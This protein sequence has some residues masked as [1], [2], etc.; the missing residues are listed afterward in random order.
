MPNNFYYSESEESLIVV[1]SDTAWQKRYFGS[2]KDYPKWVSYGIDD[3]VF[4]IT[5]QQL[6][7]QSVVVV[8]DVI[9]ATKVGHILPTLTL[10]GSKITANRIT[11]LLLLGY[12]NIILWLDPDKH[13]YMV[14]RK[15]Q[16]DKLCNCSII[17]SDKD[18]KDYRNEEIN[19]LLI[20]HKAT[21][22]EKEL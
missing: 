2:N 1:I 11:K 4:H 3:N 21:S 7:K 17:L 5:G 18:P 12:N 16:L 8:E 20:H 9:S 10:F 14:E 6:D 19:E 15:K 22:S 13:S